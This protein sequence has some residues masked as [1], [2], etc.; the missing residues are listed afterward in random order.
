MR[1][2]MIINPIEK[3]TS[4]SVIKPIEHIIGLMVIFLLLV[5]V[6]SIT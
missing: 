3:I 4:K 2:N 6:S 5:V 1:N